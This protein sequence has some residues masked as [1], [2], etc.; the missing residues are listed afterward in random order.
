MFT[1][2][3]LK[4]LS[5][6]IITFLAFCYIFQL[7]SAILFKLQKNPFFHMVY[8]VVF[9]DALILKALKI[10]FDFVNVMK[11]EKNQGSLHAVL[12]YI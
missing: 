8:S 10:C 4:V 12:F 3:I 5:N 1:I 9:S 7:F 2:A 11:C 6:V